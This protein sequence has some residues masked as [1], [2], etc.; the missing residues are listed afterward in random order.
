MLWFVNLQR[1]NRQPE[2]EFLHPKIQ[3]GG[4]SGSGFSFGFSAVLHVR[5][6]Y[7]QD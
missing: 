7:R 5:R 2:L 3:D 1:S 4:Q 6:D